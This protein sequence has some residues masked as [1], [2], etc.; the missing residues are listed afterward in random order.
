MEVT[1]GEVA[2]MMMRYGGSFVQCLGKALERADPVNAAKIKATWP[3]YWEQ[4]EAMAKMRRND[5][6]AGR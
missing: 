3:E 5:D 2:E 4:Y 1:K 6:E